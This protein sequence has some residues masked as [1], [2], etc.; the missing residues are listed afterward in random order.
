MLKREWQG[1]TDDAM[2][3]ESETMQRGHGFKA[4]VFFC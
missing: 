4:V 3:W 2:S 1:K